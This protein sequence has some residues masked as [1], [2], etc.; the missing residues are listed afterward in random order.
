[1]LAIHPDQVGIINEAFMPDAAEIARAREIVAL[2][3]KNPQAG[4]MSLRGRMVDRP[5]VVQAQ[6][7]LQMASGRDVN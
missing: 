2:F 1:M 3:E 4:T 7:I 6:K 5:H